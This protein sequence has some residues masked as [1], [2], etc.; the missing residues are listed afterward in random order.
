MAIQGGFGAQLMIDVSGLEIVAGVSNLDFPEFAKLIA[1]STGHG[2]SGG[3]GESVAAGKRSL[4]EIPFDINWDISEETHQALVTAFDSDTSYNMRVEEP[5]GDEGVSFA[6]IVMSNT[7]MSKKES[8]YQAQITIQPTGAPTTYDIYYI[9]ATSGNDSNGGNLS[10]DAWQTVGKVNGETFNPADRILWNRGDEWRET[11]IPPSDGATGNYIIFDAYG[12][13]PNPIFNGSDVMT[14][15]TSYSSNTW[16]KTG[17]TTEPLQVFM[18]D[19][20]L[21]EGSDRDSLNDHEWVWASDVLYVRDETGDPD[22]SGVEIEASQR[23]KATT[24]TGR[25]YLRFENLRFCKANQDGFHFFNNASVPEDIEVINCEI[26]TNRRENVHISGIDGIVFRGCDVHDCTDEHGFY[27]NSS[28]NPTDNITIEQCNIYN[29]NVHGIQLNPNAGY[30]ITGL[31]VR[32]NKIYDNS[33]K[34]VV[35]MCSTGA[36]YYNNLMYD[37]A[38]GAAAEQEQIFL[39]R[40]DPIE[41]TNATLYH[42]TIVIPDNANVTGLRLNPTSTGNTIKNNI[43]YARGS[44]DKIFW[45]LTNSTATLDNNDYYASDF[46]GA[47]NWQGTGYNTLAAYVAAASQDAN[48]IDDDPLFTAAGSDDFTIPTGSPCKNTGA[49]GTGVTDDYDGITRDATP[50]IGAYEYVA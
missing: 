21:T 31:I 48:A 9:D 7:R 18:D 29:N 32:R 3:Y 19:T 35:D 49:T 4:G 36:L 6:G 25:S 40:N 22:G 45:A 17:V 1:G 16:Q 13:G 39:T 33:G 41:Q 50:D 8:R 5:E 27:L 28:Q 15:W 12:S 30:N 23:D 2:S 24:M 44:F 38:A 43:F 47:W 37:N 26:D 10:S 11:F 46:T 42:N 34:A 20:R 14:T